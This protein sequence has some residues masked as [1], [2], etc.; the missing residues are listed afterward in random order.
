M[1]MQQT[2]RRQKSPW[3]RYAPFIAIVVVVAIVGVVLATRGAN[4]KDNKVAVGTPAPPPSVSGQNGIPLFYNDAKAQGVA[5]AHQWHNCDTTT[6]RVAIPILNPP[7]CVEDFSGSNGGVTSP[8]VTATTIKVGYYIAKPDPT[9]DGVLAQAGAYD[10]PADVAQAYKDYAAI[11]GGTFELY[12]RKVQLVRVD[13][14]GS[15]TD[16]VAARADADRAAADGVFAMVGGP[17]QTKAFADELSQKKILCVGTCIISQPQRYYEENEPYMWPTG[18]APDQTSTMITTFIKNQLVG[19]PA[20]Y[21]GAGLQGKTRTFTMLTYDTPDN[22]Y[23]SSWDDLETKLKATGVPVVDHV[24]YFLNI[25]TMQSDARTIATRLKQK[26]ATSILFTG[27]PIFPIFLTAE[28]TKEHYF[29]EWVMS[30]TVLADT[31]VF[32]RKFDQQQWQ[33]AFGLL[34]QPS[35]VP[36]EKQDSYTLHQWWFNGAAPTAENGFAIYKG[37]IELLFDGLQL[38]GPKL[39]PTAFRNGLDAA[40]TSSPTDKPTV[41]TIVTYGNHGYWTG[42]DPAGLDNAGI[43]FWDP[44]TAGP[45]ETGTVGKGMYRLMDGGVRY[46]TSQ[47]PKTPMALFDKAN[48]V[49]IYGDSEVP[50]LLQPKTEPLPAGAPGAT[51]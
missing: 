44:T 47:W 2:P 31:N 36:K 30:G 20:Q 45:D 4:S 19:K 3:A 33:H 32:A 38:A 1:G 43:E 24:D 26:N 14:S 51:G 35:R 7:P 48:T 18:P 25:P 17:T 12:G 22:Q 39:T 11:Y 16:S 23:R 27:D 8:G 6:G 9:L 10:P 13:G 28:M 49:T 34:L 50:A 42:D 5:T 37:D 21:A 41:R 46:L 29:P 15:S 40:P